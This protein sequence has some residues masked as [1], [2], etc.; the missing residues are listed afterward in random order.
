MSRTNRRRRDC[1][2]G[3]PFAKGYDPRRHILTQEERRR[4][5]YATWNMFMATWRAEQGLPFPFDAPLWA[6]E[7]Y[8]AR[9]RKNG[10]SSDNALSPDTTNNSEEIPL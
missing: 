9:F 1:V 7:L 2:A 3:K 8:A 10:G 6:R 5:V 4:G